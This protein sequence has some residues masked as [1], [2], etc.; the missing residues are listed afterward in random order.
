M[1]PSSRQT[2]PVHLRDWKLITLPVLSGFL[3]YA[4][5]PAISQGY[6]A[7]VAYVPLAIF[8]GRLSTFRSAFL[9]GLLVGIIQFSLLL[10]WIPGVLVQYG[11][12]STVLAWLLYG[13][14]ILILGTYPAIAAG[15]TGYAMQRR[16]PSCLLLL[17]FAWV[18]VELL[19]SYT[20]FGGFPWLLTGYSQ[21]DYLPVV[22]IADITGVY[23]LSLLILIA[24]VGIAWRILKGPAAR[25]RLW[26]ALAACGLI[27]LCLAYGHVSLR[28][29]SPGPTLRKTAILQANIPLEGPDREVEWKFQEGYLRMADALRGKTIDLLVLPE[30]P[31]P[32]S[33][34][35]DKAYQE[36]MRSLAKRYPMGLI[37]SNVATGRDEGASEYFNSAYFLDS[38][39]NLSG[40]YDKVRLVPFGEYVPFKR[41]FFFLDSI[42]REV[43]DFS[44][45]SEF[46]R[47]R[48][49][50][51]QTSAIICYEAVFPSLARRFVSG[52][53]ELL[54]NLTNDAWYG[55]TP[56]P[57]Q[58]LAMARWRAVENRRW[59]IRAANSGISAVI[60]PGG[61]IRSATGLFREEA[62]TGPFDFVSELTIYSRYG[63][64]CACLCVIISCVVLLGV[65]RAGAGRERQQI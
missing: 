17:P 3:A 54:V 42:T 60:D 6:L 21:T 65:R 41:A 2:S 40:R 64:V 31:A 13:L 37:L 15:T 48:V 14:M 63:D 11:N 51:H 39:G 52:G 43:S 5:F 35:Q 25:T 16:G 24:N 55:N 7:W 34:E 45:G 57:Y 33:F 4:S 50:G 27:L 61:R 18:S 58:H 12:I 59:L 30:S 8:V 38:D 56:A 10:C 44:A 26:P 32:K 28:K 53:S 23:G 20:P 49:G 46:L 22:Q 29:W 47:V 19:R 36:A 62:C 9:G 1:L